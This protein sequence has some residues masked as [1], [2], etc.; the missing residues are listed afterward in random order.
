[1]L[2]VRGVYYVLDGVSVRVFVLQSVCMFV[3]FYVRGFL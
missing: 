2:C 1:M 3:C